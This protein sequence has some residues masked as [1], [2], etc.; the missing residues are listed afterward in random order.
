M[1]KT[2][3]KAPGKRIGIEEPL[4]GFDVLNHS[5]L[6]SS[7]GHHG[8]HE[9]NSSLISLRGAIDDSQSHQKEDGPTGVLT[10]DTTMMNTGMKNSNPSIV[11]LHPQESQEGRHSAAASLRQSFVNFHLS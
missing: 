8:S 5:D 10:E 2:K 1:Q 4:L 3:M 6:N 7:G 11:P 9:N